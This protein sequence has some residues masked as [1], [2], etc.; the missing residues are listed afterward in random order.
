LLGLR[1]HLVDGDGARLG[2]GVWAGVAR[3]S[4]DLRELA[5]ATLRS[6][7]EASAAAVAPG[8]TFIAVFEAV[9]GDA[10]GF[11]L[12]LERLPFI[13]EPPATPVGVE[14]PP[15][16]GDIE[17]PPAVAPEVEAEPAPTAPAAGEPT[18]SSPPAS[19]PSSG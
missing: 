3:P 18:A 2:D 14:P 8:G 6:A 13:E 9:P 15:A 7:I 12:A 4:G 1:V 19:R 17:P 10:T 16:P 11:E 5:P